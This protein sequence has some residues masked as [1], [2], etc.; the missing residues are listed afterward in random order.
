MEFPFFN[1]MKLFQIKAL[2]GSQFIFHS[3]NL[4]YILKANSS[5]PD[6]AFCGVWSDSAL[7]VDVP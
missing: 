2:L 6:I 3:K 1:W 4:K 7:F 5:E